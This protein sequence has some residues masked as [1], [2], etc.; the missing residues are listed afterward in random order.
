[1]NTYTAAVDLV[2]EIAA[3][4]DPASTVVSL[5]PAAVNSALTAGCQAVCVRPPRV[6]WST[7]TATDA[8]WTVL[9]V[10]GPT[11]DS[12]RAWQALDDLLATVMAAIDPDTV[13][14]AEYLAASGTRWPAFTVEFTIPYN[15]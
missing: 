7:R 9:L 10:T 11:N 4:V 13:E 14:P 12:G 6:E 5:D 8:T 3:V 1:M 15:L 2:G